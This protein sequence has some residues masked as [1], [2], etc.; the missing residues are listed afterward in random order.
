MI[1]K[2]NIVIVAGEFEPILK[3]EMIFHFSKQHRIIFVFFF[4]ILLIT[5]IIVIIVMIEINSAYDIFL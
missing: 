4:F 3:H 5:V 2:V 1:Y